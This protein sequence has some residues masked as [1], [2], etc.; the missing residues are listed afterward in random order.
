MKKSMPRIG[1]RIIKTSIAAFL[2]LLIFTAV[3]AKR[4]PFY[5][6]I[7]T[8]ICIQPDIANTKDTAFNRAIGTLIG[9]VTGAVAMFLEMPVKGL[10]GGELWWDLLNAVMICITIYLTVLLGKQYI[11][12]MACVAYLSVAVITH[13][14]VSPYEFLFYRVVDTFLGVGIGSLVGSFHT[15]GK[16]RNDVLFVAELDDELR[17]AHR[18]ISEFNK[19]A[20]NHMIDEGALFTMITRQTPASLI[21]EVEHLKLRLPVIALDGAVLYDIYQN[22]YLHTCL[23]EHDMGIRI[24]Q[25]LTEQNRA[26]FTNVIVDDVWVIYYNDLVDEDQKGYL[27]KLRTSPYRNYMRR[28]PH[29]E[30]HILYFSVLDT[31]NRLIMLEKQLEEMGFAGKLKFLL[32]DH[33]YGEKSLLKILSIETS[34]RNM[35]DRLMKML[36]VHHSIVYGDKDSETCCDVAVA[37]SD[38]NRI[39]QNIRADYTGR[40]RKTRVSKKLEDIRN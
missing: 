37:D 38:F 17:S 39:V 36:H 40:K 24:R 5:V 34:P 4:S 33:V 13:D 21:A 6:L 25:L 11:A 28:A 10:P 18:Q 7:T 30:D 35:L 20:L 29:D 16:K 1:M 14:G 9:A 27:K 22:R 23:M 2:I 26:F 12:F 32:E 15:H 31:H 8:I 19:T 3:G